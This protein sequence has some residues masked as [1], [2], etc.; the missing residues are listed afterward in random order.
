MKLSI[1]ISTHHGDEYGATYLL[2]IE[3]NGVSC[4]VRLRSWYDDF[5]VREEVYDAFFRVF[6]KTPTQQE[7]DRISEFVKNNDIIIDNTSLLI[8]K[9]VN[10]TDRFKN[11]NRKFNKIN[12]IF[13]DYKFDSGEVTIFHR[14]KNVEKMRSS[15][16]SKK[17]IYGQV[18]D[19]LDEILDIPNNKYTG[20]DYNTYLSDATHE[21]FNEI[22]ERIRNDPKFMNHVLISINNIVGQE[23]VNRLYKMA[24]VT[25]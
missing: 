9:F 7:C 10:S 2:T 12:I 17:I 16:Q 5:A 8:Q 6:N 24:K 23:T 25:G 3:I 18:S 15:I 4:S 19:I 1:D 22:Y 21:S 20:N 11:V 14:S 13:Y